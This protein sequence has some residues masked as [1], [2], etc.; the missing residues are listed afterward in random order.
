MRISDWSSDVCSSDLLDD[1]VLLRADGTPNYM[2]SVVV[3]D[4]DMGVTHVIR[5]YDHLNN[6]FRQF[7][8]YRASAWDIPAFAHIPLNHGPEGQ[9]LSKRHG[10]KTV[11]PAGRGRGGKYE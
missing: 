4:H 10:A 3:D 8:L 1:F 5:G 11:R 9:K 2:L 6:T 7:H